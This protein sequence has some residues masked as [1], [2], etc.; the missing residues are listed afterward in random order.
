MGNTFSGTHVD[1]TGQTVTGAGLQMAGYAQNIEIGN[2]QLSGQHIEVGGL[3][4]NSEIKIGATPNN[5]L[6]NSVATLA[7]SKIVIGGAYDST[8]SQSYTR[9]GT[10]SLIAD[11]DVWI[12]GWPNGVNQRSDQQSVNLFT[13]AGT[14]NFFSN[15]GGPSN[16]N[17]ATNASDVNIAGQ[18][19]TTT[20]NNRL[21][22]NASAKFLSDIWLCG[23][24]SAFEF[25]SDRGQLGTTI[26]SH[27][28]GLTPPYTVV[29]P[30]K[31]VDILNVIKKVLADVG[32]YN[33]IDTAGSGLWGGYNFQ[34]TPAGETISQFPDL[35]GTNE[36]YLPLKYAPITNDINGNPTVQYFVVGDYII[37][38]TGI[39]GNSI[40]P[41]VAQI[42]ELTRTTVAP[43]FLKVKRQP[44]G[45]FT[46]FHSDHPDTTPIY[47]VNVQ[48]DSTWTEN[49][50]DNTGPQDQVNLAEFGGTLSTDDY[51]IIGRSDTNQDGTYDFGEALKIDQITG[52]VNQKLTVSNCGEPDKVVFEVDSVTGEVT[53]GN[54]DIPGS[55][56]NINTTIK[57]QGGCGTIK[58]EEI[59]GSLVRITGDDATYYI[60]GVSATDIAKVS[61]GDEIRYNPTYGNF[62]DIEFPVNYVTEVKTDSIRLKN[63][64]Y[65]SNI[66]TV[67]FYISQNETLTLTNG[68]EQEV[69][70]VDSCSA[71]TTIGNHIRRVELSE[72]YP[73]VKT[74][75]ETETAFGTITDQ[76]TV[77]SYSYD[78]VTDNNGK[79]TTVRAAVTAHSSYDWVIPVQSVGE[80]NAAFE[81]G[82]LLVVG[83]S[84]N[85][86]PQ[87]IDGSSVVVDPG[88][89]E[90]LI[91]RGITTG[92]SPEL[93]CDG[94]QEGTTKASAGDYTVN[95]TI[96]VIK[97]HS[98]VSQLLDLESKTRGSVEYVSAILN[99]GYIVQTRIDYV[100]YVRFENLTT[101]DNS[102]FLLNSNLQGTVNSA[103]INHERQSGSLGYNKGNLDIGGNINMIGGDIEIFDSV[104]SSRLL[105]FKNDGGHADHLGS[106]QL[107][108]GVV[109]KGA[110][111]MYPENCPETVFS[112]T[113]IVDPTFVV[114][115]VGNVS[116][117]LTLTV[118]GESNTN[119]T[120]Q[121]EIF[122]VDKLNNNGSDK[123]SIK[124]TGE[125]EAFGVEPFWT[126][127]GGR[128]TRYV[129][130]GSDPAAKTLMAN[131]IY[132]A[133]VDI[134]NTLV[135]TL[136]AEVSTGDVIKIVDVGGNLNHKTSLVVRAPGVGVRVQGD[137]TGT[138]LAEGGGF[139]ANSYNSGE[140]V[141]QT[142]NA[143]FSLVYL[144]SVDSG[145]GVGI[146]S[147]QQGWWLMEI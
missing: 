108:A 82:D 105:Y 143:A 141:V 70:N 118:T 25:I 138:T 53:I 142:P 58:R 51:I 7:D 85:T 107:D 47:K 95:D 30:N 63:P 123:F 56:V 135:L 2:K 59:V 28:N 35:T 44:F 36:Y 43:Y 1:N 80:G 39:S 73:S 98:E 66:S 46:G 86:A 94:G 45:T 5:Y 54:P 78:P 101:G 9:I 14:V 91:V 113:G 12:G 83:T 104:N 145:G 112:A 29:D 127:T 41:E 144:G 50:L 125:I 4:N 75:S 147:T 33:Q 106:L 131:I 22:V 89:H 60:S 93:I 21:Q 109:L 15:S 77:Y 11:G 114:D 81:I 96:L 31:N 132:C 119:P 87:T 55:I 122:T 68:N 6:L 76:V 128:H 65:G 18:G 124:H 62:T 23:G 117:K 61:V 27:D 99:R 48:F 84:A 137:S 130:T 64:V 10:K 69:F 90:I 71:N 79:K 3:S 42:T 140:L 74:P 129:S 24:T 111:T 100:N 139:L 146:P 38:D 134:D 110:L 121:S 102:F 52:Q 120:P 32:E 72:F 8:E 16:I 136:P 49:D 20:I 126:R 115:N 67:G 133:A 57:L 92:A 13:P 37:I 116:A 103:V 19:G 34:G 26:S 88:F 97:K 40:F 17:F